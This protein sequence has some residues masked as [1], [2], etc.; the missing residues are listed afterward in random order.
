MAFITLTEK[1]KKSIAKID[2]VTGIPNKSGFFEGYIVRASFKE[3]KNGAEQ[4]DFT[5]ATDLKDESTY[6]T[7]YGLTI[8]NRDKKENIQGMTLMKS[9]MIVCGLDEVANPVKKQVKRRNGETVIENV[10]ED[11]S[12]MHIRWKQQREFQMYNNEIKDRLII[13]KFYRGVDGATASEIING[14]EPRQYYL[15]IEYGVE[16]RFDNVTKE[17]VD[18]YLKNKYLTTS[19]KNIKSPFDDKEE[20]EEIPF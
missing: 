15:D 6:R 7:I 5:L 12:N 19:D 13:R 16:D 20:L 9:L 10:L 4:I 14:V 18:E 3:T 8:R 1:E 2:G 11:F 17:E